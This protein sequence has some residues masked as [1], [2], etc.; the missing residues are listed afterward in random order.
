MDLKRRKARG[1][2]FAHGDPSFSLRRVRRG[3]QL[4]PVP[5]LGAR[6]RPVVDARDADVMQETAGRGR[7]LT[8]T[9][10]DL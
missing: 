2:E 4:A 1:G 7:L 6:M 10:V 5:I 3:M 8:V 9:P